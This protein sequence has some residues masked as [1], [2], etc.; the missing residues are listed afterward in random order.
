MESLNDLNAQLDKMGELIKEL[1]ESEVKEMK[2]NINMQLYAAKELTKRLSEDEEYIE[3]M[4]VF[5]DKVAKSLQAKGYNGD[6]TIA[7]TCALI[8]RR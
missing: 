3:D 5:V 8:G 7:L 6:H 4:A 1:D 2:N